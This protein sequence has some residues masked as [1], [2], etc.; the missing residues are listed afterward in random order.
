MRAASAI[1]EVELAT[2]SMIFWQDSQIFIV[3]LLR[4]PLFS[5]MFMFTVSDA[6][7]DV[8]DCDVFGGGHGMDKKREVGRRTA[9]SNSIAENGCN[10]KY[11]STT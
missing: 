6:L 8:V 1:R 5:T 2:V 10:I 3:S 7:V 9:G 4:L 11:G